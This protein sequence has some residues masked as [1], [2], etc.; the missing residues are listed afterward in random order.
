MLSS[1]RRAARLSTISVLLALAGCPDPEGRYNEFANR[2]PDAPI[3]IMPDAPKLNMIPDI[4]GTFLYSIFVSL[5]P[6][7]A[8]LESIATITVHQGPPLTADI[9]IQWLTYTGHNPIDRLQAD[10]PGQT[11]DETGTFTVSVPAL[12]IPGEAGFL[13]NDVTATDVHLVG[14]IKTA[15]FFCGTVDG[16]ALTASLAGSTFGAL[17]IQAGQSGSQLPPPLDSC[18]QQPPAGD[19]G[20]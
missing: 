8:P 9:H 11:V 17:R 16:T 10:Y 1:N 18:A 13:G 19:G 7:A 5:F 12:T 2:V 6:Q 4:S 15:N 20:L 14:M 3:V